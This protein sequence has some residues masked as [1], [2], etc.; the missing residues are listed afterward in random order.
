MATSFR[1]S[2][3]Q[4]WVY[5]LPLILYMVTIFLLSGFSHPEK[6]LP[7]AFLLPHDKVAHTLEYAI[8]GILCV[9]AFHHG[10]GR[11]AIRHAIVWAILCSTLYG[12]T[13]EYHQSFVPYRE[14]DQWDLVADFLGASLGA[15]GWKLLIARFP[16]QASKNMR[17]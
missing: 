11:Q 13:D 2:S 15:V 7:G 8:L 5:W 17:V 1:P 3:H 12:L 16:T 4:I 9:R 10:L 14:S 6:D